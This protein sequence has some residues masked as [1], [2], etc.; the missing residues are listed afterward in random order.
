MA[1]LGEGEGGRPFWRNPWGIAFVAGALTLTFLRPCTRYVPDPP[2]VEGE[3]S[4]AVLAYADGG[5][6]SFPAGHEVWIV[7]Y[8][9]GECGGV[10]ELML[11]RV[12]EV[13]ERVVSWGYDVGVVVVGGGSLAMP[14]GVRAVSELE[15][16]LGSLWGASGAGSGSL[17]LVDASGGIRGRYDVRRSDVSDELFFRAE[18]VLM[19]RSGGG[20]GGCGAD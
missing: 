20:R 3:A 6:V 11:T 17:V 12:G 15:G 9:G 18:H 2:P 7:G 19:S 13:G 8:V 5:E 16:E 1:E 4:E 14:A 10:C